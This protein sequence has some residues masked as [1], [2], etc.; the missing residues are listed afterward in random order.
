MVLESGKLAPE[1][2]RLLN[3]SRFCAHGVN[4]VARA[5]KPGAPCLFLDADDLR[6][7]H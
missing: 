5:G 3:L 7:R 1:M 6:L 2:V 4:P